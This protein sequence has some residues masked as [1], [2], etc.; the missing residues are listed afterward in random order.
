MP[1]NSDKKYYDFE[2]L[3][4]ERTRDIDAIIHDFFMKYWDCIQ[5]DKELITYQIK[6]QIE[7]DRKYLNDLNGKGQDLLNRI[8]KISYLKHYVIPEKNDG[9]EYYV[10]CIH[11]FI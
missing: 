8:G 5:G 1:I 4:F 3:F 7:K 6:K 11:T 9:K 10:Y 2:E